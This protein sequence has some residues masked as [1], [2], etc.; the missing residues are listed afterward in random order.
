MTRTALRCTRDSKKQG[1]ELD[2]LT[3]KRSVYHKGRLKYK[4]N[5][6]AVDLRN[7][8]TWY[9]RKAEPAQGLRPDVSNYDLFGM[10][11]LHLRSL[12]LLL[13]YKLSEIPNVAYHEQVA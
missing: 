4:T 6:Q 13:Y 2:Y 10:H 7:M 11:S 3:Q 1:K 9:F 8:T 5:I 12:A